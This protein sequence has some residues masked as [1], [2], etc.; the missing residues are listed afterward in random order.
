VLFLAAV[1]PLRAQNDAAWADFQQKAAAW[2]A[3][4]VKP[5]IPEGVRVASAQAESAFQKKRLAD[6]AA[7]YDTGLKI[8]PV[9]PEGYL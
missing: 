7:D 1:C 2:R 3:L 8:D 4:P 9:W 6:A 5:A